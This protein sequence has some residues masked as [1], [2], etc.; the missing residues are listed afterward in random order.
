MLISILILKAIDSKQKS[1]LLSPVYKRL[2]GIFAYIKKLSHGCLSATSHS[3]VL[4][5]LKYNFC[6][7]TTTNNETYFLVES[8]INLN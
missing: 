5:I 4:D 3:R 7:T 8:N 2:N 1:N 6:R